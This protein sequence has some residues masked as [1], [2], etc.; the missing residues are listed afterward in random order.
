MKK[1]LYLHI[2]VHRTGTTSLQNFL[3]A[4]RTN[5]EA[6]GFRYAFHAPHHTD[7]AWQM[8][9][10]KLD[11][12][13]LVADLIRDIEDYGCHSMILSGEDFCQLENVQTLRLLLNHFD[14]RIICYLRRQDLWL[15][16]WYNQ[17]IRWPWNKEF[18]QLSAAAFFERRNEFHW[19]D[20]DRMLT[21]WADVFGKDNLVVRVFEK[22]QLARPLETDF[23]DICG[24]DATS[25]EL[26]RR[27]FNASIPI[28]ALELLRHL[29][30]YDKG[31]R[32]RAVIVQAV[33]DAYTKARADIRSHIFSSHR[34]LSV[35]RDF[36]ESNARVARRF[37]GRTDG[38][39]FR[40]PLPEHNDSDAWPTLLPVR[41][42]CDEIVNPIV[43]KLLER[44]DRNEKRARALLH[45]D[46]EMR[47]LN[48]E[49]AASLDRVRSL[50][51]TVDSP[52]SLLK[53]L[54]RQILPGSGK[55]LKNA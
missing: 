42:L 34:R 19:I 53:H 1:K 38:V 8:L 10:G 21:R 52:T 48:E 23:C 28:D 51:N 39:L 17:H 14:V 50:R 13:T 11:A 16:S 20:Y 27:Q 36:E 6:Q 29:D 33:T 15:E 24:I 47:A 2:G 55:N 9:L 12:R 22:G 3:F 4:N 44:I 18:S 46:E 41:E 5:L 32:Q 43:R 40:D 26:P 25:L 35:L 30:L 49:K 37:L 7:L 45:D 31:D 54:F